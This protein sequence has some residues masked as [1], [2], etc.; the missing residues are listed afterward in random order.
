MRR[1]NEKGLELI[2]KFE[3]LRLEPYICSGGKKTVGYGHTGD[4]ARADRRITEIEAEAALRQDLRGAERD[5]ERLVK[6]PVSDNQF[7]ALVS[8]V[9]NLGAGS[10]SRSTLLRKLNTGD[11]TGASEEFWKWRR[12]GGKILKGLVRRRA[13][14]KELFLS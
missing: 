11:Y 13:A 3:G 6:V 4:L 9:F 12:A 2:K 7:S 5:V 1:I 8:F 14:E 10:L